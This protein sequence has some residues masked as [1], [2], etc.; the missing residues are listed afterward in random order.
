M[1]E[2]A[3]II[4]AAGKGTRM[5]S[6]LAKALH[7]ANG[8]PLAWYPI[9]RALELGCDPVVVV[10]GHQGDEVRRQLAAHFPGAPLRFA[11][12][13]E[14]L[15]TGHAVLCARRALAGHKGR[16]T[17]LYGDVPLLER[18]TLEKLIAAGKGHLVAFLT[19]NPSDPT[20]Y[21]RVIRGLDGKVRA[22]VEEKDATPDERQVRE[23]NGGLYDCDA[24]F[25]WKALAKV[26]SGNAQREFYLTDLVA[27][28]ARAGDPAV[29]VPTPVDELQ[30]VNDR[31]ELAEAGR[32]LRRRVAEGHMRAGVGIVDP[33]AVY[34]ENEAELAPGATIEPNVWIAGR[35]SVG[36]GSVIG[37]GSVLVDST[38]GEGVVV[39]PYSVL[40]GAVVGDRAIVG[41]FARLRPG[42]ELGAE[43][44]IGNFVETKKTTMGRG[45]KANHLAYLGD[46]M[47]GERCNVGAGTITCNYDGVNKLPTILG[48]DV[49][50]GSDTQLVAP[51]T[52]GDGAYVGAGATVTADVPAGALALSR[53]P[54]VV[55]EGWA[56]RKRASAKAASSAKGASSKISGKS[57]ASKLAPASKNSAAKSTASKISA[58]A[59][60][61]SGSKA[62]AG[63]TAAARSSAAKTTEARRSA[64][65]ASGSKRPRK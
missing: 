41:P 60:K 55:K 29:A 24:R 8:K 45:S 35:S 15:G 30:G 47:I 36:A 20:G 12:Q 11:V 50:I 14:Q 4:L 56:D 51:V 17:I 43:V 62:V 39:K 48:D 31:V 64:V 5:K 61:A 65:R 27:A 10:V 7:E 3:A 63:K 46:A 9:Q 13:E 32:R 54:Q 6:G 22:I 1:S 44:H 19:M 26:D 18:P 59:S 37:F 21:G 34:L 53:A 58:A 49:F 2:R 42:T 28:A 16:I 25:L 52:I 23:A 57:K 33:D 40:E 38:V